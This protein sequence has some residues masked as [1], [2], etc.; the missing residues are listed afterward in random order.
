MVLERGFR[1]L[2]FDILWSPKSSS[3]KSYGHLKL[4]PNLEDPRND[5]KK[6]SLVLFGTQGASSSH[7]NT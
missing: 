5:L 1:D 3:N 6:F 2:S 4:T 7:F